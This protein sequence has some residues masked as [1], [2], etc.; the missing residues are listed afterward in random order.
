MIHSVT[1]LLLCFTCAPRESVSAGILWSAGRPAKDE[2][3]DE[4]DGET[5]GKQQKQGERFDVC[6]E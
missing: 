6:D 1:H 5:E 3:R 4:D 2:W